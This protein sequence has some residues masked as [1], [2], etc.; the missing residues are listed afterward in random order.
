MLS[1]YILDSLLKQT[2]NR[3]VTGITDEAMENLLDYDWPGNIREMEY[4]IERSVLMTTTDRI[5]TVDITG[6]TMAG[7][8]AT[9]A[10]FQVRMLETMERKHIF[11]R[12][13]FCKGKVFGPGGAAEM[14]NIPSSTLT[15]KI[16]KLG[17]KN[18][19]VK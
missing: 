14:L 15:S 16:K 17:I 4:L 8:A 13:K 11:E 2:T 10:D 7:T 6:L 19:Y 12:L 1:N 5:E 3:S 9:N 18:E